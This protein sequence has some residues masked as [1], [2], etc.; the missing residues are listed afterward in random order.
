MNK[1]ET[2]LYIQNVQNQT[3][4]F[5]SKDTQLNDSYQN[6]AASL[7]QNTDSMAAKG[8]F[9]HNYLEVNRIRL[10][11]I[12]MSS[13]LARKIIDCP[14]D[15]MLSGGVTFTGCTADEAKQLQLK[16]IELNI[17]HDYGEVEKQARLYGGCVG[18]YAIDGQ[19][20]ST[21]LNIDRVGQD[22]FLGIEPLSRWQV[23][24][25]IST[26]ITVGFNRGEPRMYQVMFDNGL[27]ATNYNLHYSRLV[28]M[29]GYNVPW[30][31]KIALLW[32]GQSILTNLLDVITSYEAISLAIDNLLFKANLK[33]LKIKGLK[34]LNAME[35]DD[36]E[37]PNWQQKGLE[38]YLRTMRDL[39]S[40]ES[41][42]VLDAD[43]DYT[44]LQYAF[45]GLKE[46]QESKG[47]QVSGASGTPQ[48]ILFGR[49]ADGLGASLAGDIE[50]WLKKLL[51]DLETKHRRPLSIIFHLLWKTT[52]DTD[53]P[54]D[55]GFVFN[56]LRVMDS[57]QV[58][59]ITSKTVDT[60]VR[61]VEANIITPQEARDELKSR[62]N[63]LRLFSELEAR[64]PSEL[65]K[66]FDDNNLKGENNI[67]LGEEDASKI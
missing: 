10:E 16:M 47:E 61:A 7:G 12:Y 28:K 38:S 2:L 66:D 5:F 56:P 62:S 18:H 67:I 31:Q 37:E 59:E 45:Q 9:T 46:I 33:I 53:V 20:P 19:N 49:P 32:W 34:Q 1:R 40:N 3:E 14:V 65:A 24:P 23:L 8:Y 64:L 29:I 52:F 54:K 51:T 42:T 50:I 27:D 39:Q 55:F 6:I 36:D 35:T 48:S 41:V 4:G 58:A 57:D 13:W 30:F 63:D 60:L 21:E 22:Q 11:N 26:L 43:D 15:T 25:D 17:W 44:N